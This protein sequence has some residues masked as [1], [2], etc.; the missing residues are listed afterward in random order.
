MSII[1]NRNET[2]ET[3][4]ALPS[5][6]LSAYER[7]NESVS[8][9]E[10]TVHNILTDQET[11]INELSTTINE[12]KPELYPITQPIIIH[13]AIDQKI[14]L[15]STTRED[16]I[17]Y[18]CNNIQHYSQMQTQGLYE[19]II[20][21]GDLD[22]RWNIPIFGMNNNALKPVLKIAIL[23]HCYECE[24]SIRFILHY[25]SMIV[26]QY[27]LMEKN[28]F[29]QSSKNNSVY[30]DSRPPY[31]FLF[32]MRYDI[33]CGTY[34]IDFNEYTC[35]QA[36][37]KFDYISFLYSALVLLMPQINAWFSK[38][39][40]KLS[41]NMDRH[42]IL[43]LHDIKTWC[44]N[45]VFVTRTQFF[46]TSRFIHMRVQNYTNSII[47]SLNFE[48]TPAASLITSDSLTKHFKL[49]KGHKMHELHFVSK[50]P[51]KN[52]LITKQFNVKNTSSNS[53]SIHQAKI[54]SFFTHFYF[55][56]VHAN[57][58]FEL[59]ISLKSMFSTN[60]DEIG[61]CN[62]WINET[63]HEITK[64]IDSTLISRITKSLNRLTR[65]WKFVDLYEQN[66]YKN[67]DLV[68]L[69]YSY[70]IIDHK[71]VTNLSKC[72]G[73][74][75]N[76]E[77]CPLF[78]NTIAWNYMI[79]HGHICPIINIDQ[80]PLFNLR[81]IEGECLRILY[82]YDTSK[83][84]N[85]FKLYYG[86]IVLLKS[87]NNAAATLYHLKE[88]KNL[89]QLIQDDYI[90]LR[91]TIS[92]Q[93]NNYRQCNS[94]FHELINTIECNWKKNSLSYL[95]DEHEWL[96]S[97]TNFNSSKE[98]SSFNSINLSNDAT[99]PSNQT[100]ATL[101]PDNS[102]N[103]LNNLL[104][105]NLINSNSTT[106]HIQS[107]DSIILLFSTYC[108]LFCPYQYIKSSENK[109]W[110]ELSTF[111]QQMP[112]SCDLLHKI[113]TAVRNP[114][115]IDEIGKQSNISPIGRTTVNA[116][117]FIL[118]GVD[119]ILCQNNINAQETALR[120][121]LHKVCL[122]PLDRQLPIV[123]DAQ[124]TILQRCSQTLTNVLKF[125]NNDI[126][127]TIND[128]IFTNLSQIFD[129]QQIIPRLVDILMRVD[130]LYYKP[131]E[132]YLAKCQQVKRKIIDDK[133]NGCIDIKNIPNKL[134][135]AI[136]TE[137]I[138]RQSQFKRQ[139]R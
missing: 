45:K 116:C 108:R 21:N 57:T 7:L 3:I 23:S 125:T 35:E 64:V 54:P 53:V 84:Y 69:R 49:I 126:D 133:A 55:S 63:L 120:A 70:S 95:P 61:Q 87:E 100:S 129:N 113:V 16:V 25:I 75:R 85:Y 37:R 74:D 88:D 137:I 130:S 109:A 97:F 9:K 18:W 17:Q 105:D 77:T 86:L 118:K 27:Y 103:L 121:I 51:L 81:T 131:V 80:H 98:N 13:P 124:E 123:D 76:S 14:W 30:N 44:D 50:A 28:Q 79:S 127:K 132:T 65:T 10:Y 115:F 40:E 119:E 101:L 110:L 62:T 94:Q 82:T 38:N 4:V 72:I 15:S 83:Q 39:E 139:K 92:Y 73:A 46:V 48:N 102:T 112:K 136:G 36:V 5:S 56:P 32:F 91:N 114:Q 52:N 12:T 41:R 22:V 34:P 2:I 117:L 66:E 26:L 96:Q 122:N 47:K 134:H 24:E 29:M 6:L 138:L 43:T 106:L 89:L 58:K 135:A 33:K 93:M 1:L 42:L 107:H 111:E 59:N 31:I 60:I 11:F 67:I 8:D 90:L 19:R 78:I 68:R 104:C 99:E 71:M 128:I 20:L